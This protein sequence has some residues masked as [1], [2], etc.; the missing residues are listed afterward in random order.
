[1]K[2]LYPAKFSCYF[3]KEKRASKNTLLKAIREGCSLTPWYP[4]YLKLFNVSPLRSTPPSMR[5][6]KNQEGY[7]G[8]Y[9]LKLTWCRSWREESYALL[10]EFKKNLVGTG[11]KGELGKSIFRHQIYYLIIYIVLL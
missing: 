2:K 3:E 9:Q 10:L 8:T 7:S 6:S 1:M 4:K 11:P 5:K